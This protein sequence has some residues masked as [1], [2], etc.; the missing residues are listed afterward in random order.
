MEGEWNKEDYEYIKKKDLKCWV[1]ASMDS[2]DTNLSATKSLML[3]LFFVPVTVTSSRT[4]PSID[5]LIKST[6]IAIQTDPINAD[7]TDEKEH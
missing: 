7:R 1:P 6:A 3:L 5:P 4:H 2:L